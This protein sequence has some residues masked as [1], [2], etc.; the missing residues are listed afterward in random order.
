MRLPRKHSMTNRADFARA[1]KDGQAKAGRF[2]VLSTL[3][4]PALP[5]LKCA[6]ITTRKVGKAHDRNLLRRRIRLSGT[7]LRS[8]PLEEKIAL[9]RDFSSAVLPLFSSGRIVPVVDSVFP[10]ADVRK[11]HERM[12]TNQSFGKIILTW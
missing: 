6:V 11:A 12:E 8:R 5:H 10:F 4:D 9:A 2:V 1:R 3:A 7:V